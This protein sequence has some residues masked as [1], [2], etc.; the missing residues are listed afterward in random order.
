MSVK[1]ELKFK[2]AGSP[3]KVFDT[4]ESKDYSELKKYHT[5]LSNLKFSDGVK[6]IEVRTTRKEVEI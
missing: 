1:Y 5:A 4:Y 6:V 2:T 3:W